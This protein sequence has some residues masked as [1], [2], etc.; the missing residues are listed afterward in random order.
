MTESQEYLHKKMTIGDYKRSK[1]DIIYF[2]EKFMNLELTDRMR[3][4]LKHYQ[5]IM[6][7]GGKVMFYGG[8]GRAKVYNMRII[9]GYKNLPEFIK[10]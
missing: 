5:K 6:D 1:E 7:K 8:R 9:E 10:G 2:A 4:D 3:E